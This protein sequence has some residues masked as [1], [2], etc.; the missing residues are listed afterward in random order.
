MRILFLA[1]DA[2][3]GHGGIA[4]YNRCLARALTEI[5]EVQEIVLLVRKFS[6]PARD[7]PHKIRFVTASAG[8]KLHYVAITLAQCLKP[9]D[10][11]ICGHINLLSLAAFIAKTKRVPL[12]LQVHGID[13]WQPVETVQRWLAQIDGVWAVSTI[14]RDRMNDWANL[15]LSKYAVIPNTIHLEHYGLAPK[16]L[17]LL[18][19]YGLKDRKVIV[20]LGRLSS[21]EQYKGFDEIMEVIPSL[22]EHEPS[23]AY[24]ILGDGDD[25]QR[26]EQKAKTLGIAERVRFAGYVDEQDKADHLRLGDVFAMPGRG[27]GFGIVYLEAMACGIPV[28]ASRLDGSREALRDGMLGTLVNPDDL[29]SVQ[30]GLLSALAQPRQIPPGLD[31]FEWNNFAQRVNTSLREVLS[32]NSMA[33]PNEQRSQDETGQ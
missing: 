13:V 17:D 8:G 21:V 5:P 4:Y 10:L 24:L 22:V 1:T 32:G 7:T 27:E 20:A 18:D 15:P 26:L 31:Y 25:R 3:G 9:F 29:S 11:I 12:V 28:V 19:Q 2:Y 33:I 16:R 23:L 30:E 14:T 6:P